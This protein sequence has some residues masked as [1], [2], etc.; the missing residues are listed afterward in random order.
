MKI[1]LSLQTIAII[2]LY[3]NSSHSLNESNLNLNIY[4]KVRYLTLKIVLDLL[5]VTKIVASIPFAVL[6]H[7]IG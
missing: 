6:S 1:W 5:M 3:S 7:N 2:Y 4:L